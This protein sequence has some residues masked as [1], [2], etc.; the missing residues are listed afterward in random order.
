MSCIALAV[1]LLLLGSGARALAQTVTTGPATPSAGADVCRGGFT[2]PRCVARPF[3]VTDDL[4][5]PANGFAKAA[6]AKDALAGYPAIHDPAFINDGFYG[7]G[8]SWIAGSAASWV[9]VDLGVRGQVNGIRFGRDRTGGF[10]DR[11]P[12]SFQVMVADADDVYATGNDS[13]DATEYRTVFDSAAQRFGGVITGAQTLSVSF[14]TVK[15]RY[16]KVRF[17]A[18]GAAIDE[19][20]VSGSICAVGTLLD[21]GITCATRTEIA[22]SAITDGMTVAL[23]VNGAFHAEQGKGLVVGA[24]GGFIAPM[25]DRPFFAGSDGALML[26]DLFVVEVASDWAA[27]LRFRNRVTRKY[28]AISYVSRV[29]TAVERSAANDIFLTWRRTNNLHLAQPEDLDSYLALPALYPFDGLIGMLRWVDE[30]P[31]NQIPFLKFFQV[32]ITAAP[33]P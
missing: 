26:R 25:P 12:G 19:L 28:L 11:D 6:V 5:S 7:N 3:V 31:P 9:K 14:P 18:A 32:T 4:A 33:R 2:K 30:A 27:S 21:D 8:A 10:N 24:W 13:N 23:W 16:V 1:G 22:P 20:E 15:A 17:D 29:L